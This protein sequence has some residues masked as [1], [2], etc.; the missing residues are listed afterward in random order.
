MKKIFPFLAAGIGG[1]AAS[2]LVT[3]GIRLLAPFC[4]TT[5]SVWLD[6]AFTALVALIFGFSLGA[7][8]SVKNPANWINA[9][10]LIAGVW[11]ILILWMKHPL[12]LFIEPLGLRVAALLVIA[13]LFF[14]PYFLMGT[15]FP[16]A[17]RLKAANGHITGA[18]S[19]FI[20][21]S[22]I[23][24]IFIGYLTV[25]FLLL[26]I[27]ITHSLLLVGIVLLIS[28][29]IGWLFCGEV[30]SI[31]TSAA[32]MALAIAAIIYPPYWE[33]ADP[34]R[35]LIAVQQSREGELRIIDTDAGRYLLDNGKVIGF[36]DVTT[37]I[38]YLHS[39][40]VMELPKYFIDKPGKVLLFGLGAGSLVK[41]YCSE[42]W[43]VDV[44]EPDPAIVQMV[45]EYFRLDTWQ[46]SLFEMNAR[47]FLSTSRDSFDVILI[48]TRATIN[49]SSFTTRNILSAVS[50]H[51]RSN[52]I[53]ALNVETIGWD[54]PLVGRLGSALKE[55]FHSVF[56]LPM[57]E[58]PDQVGDVVLFASNALLQPLRPLPVNVTYNPD[59]RFGPGYQKVHAWDNRF[60]PVAKDVPSF[61]ERINPFDN[62]A[63]AINFAVRQE[64]FANFKKKDLLW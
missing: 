36:T 26:N 62:R 58:P 16:L 59:W 37:Y 27:G 61:F 33:R 21:T 55:H 10:L 25:L 7:R 46:G 24:G 31:K 52:G 9:D 60:T 1:A 40:S 12:L 34:S 18:S 63:D 53:L 41:Q 49:Y 30:R 47:Q 48:D 2:A 15:I 28:S 57:E 11:S 35:G 19:Y 32:T 44:V 13:F 6:F 42:G 45:R 38:P 43:S 23:A 64:F 5:F 29:S 14:P 4:G 56:A 8:M 20:A 54:D 17:F 51:L 3:M 39:T 22:A 50:S